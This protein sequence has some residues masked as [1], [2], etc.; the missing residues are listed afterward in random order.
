ME[1]ID[2]WLKIFLDFLYVWIK[3]HGNLSFLE[4]IQSY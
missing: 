2:F 3:T 4:G 1:E